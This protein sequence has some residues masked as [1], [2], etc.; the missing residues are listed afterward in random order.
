VAAF[1]GWQ[2]NIYRRNVGW[3]HSMPLAICAYHAA[4]SAK[5]WR[6]GMAAAA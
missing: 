4:A 6:I 2:R 1:S 5:A 3:R